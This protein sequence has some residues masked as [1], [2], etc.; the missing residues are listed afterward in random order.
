MI[1]LGAGIEWETGSTGVGVGLEVG[2]EVGFGVGEGAGGVG[3]EVGSIV[4]VTDGVSAISV[5]HANNTATPV[6]S[7]DNTAHSCM[8]RILRIG[9]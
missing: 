8:N 3:I 4:A 6:S 9:G 1:R 7:T 5:E 2:V